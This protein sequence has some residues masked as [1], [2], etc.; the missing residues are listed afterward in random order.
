M[1]LSARPP[2]QALL[3]RAQVRSLPKRI[4]TLLLVLAMCGHSLES[5]LAC[6]KQA[7]RVLDKTASSFRQNQN[8]IQTGDLRHGITGSPRDWSRN[9]W[10]RLTSKFSY[11]IGGNAAE[12]VVSHWSSGGARW[13]FRPVLASEH[14][15]YAFSD[16][17]NSNVVTN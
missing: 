8:L 13:R 6:A 11:P 14:A 3:E 2:R 4:M 10:G 7:G 17:Y 12:L 9:L 5:A 1:A 16:E 15:E